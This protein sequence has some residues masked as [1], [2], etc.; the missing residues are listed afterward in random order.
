VSVEG[1]LS[2][3][4]EIRERNRFCLGERRGGRKA[5]TNGRL[6]RGNCEPTRT[7]KK[8]S[9]PHEGLK[10]KRIKP[11]YTEE[12]KVSPKEKK[13][14]DLGRKSLLQKKGK[15][16]KTAATLPRWEDRLL[17]RKKTRT[18]REENNGEGGGGE[19]QSQGKKTLSTQKG[20]PLVPS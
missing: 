12:G 17:Q 7:L 3:H 9:S 13:T 19:S 6:S 4:P 18:S 1:V 20:M 14:S 5:Q 16:G 10:K 15:G 8:W 11:P 2:A